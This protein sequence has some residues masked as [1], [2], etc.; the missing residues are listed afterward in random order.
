MLKNSLLAPAKL[1]AAALEKN[2]WEAA[3]KLR[4]NIDAAEYKHVVLGLFFLR[5][6]YVS[7][8]KLYDRITLGLPPYKG[9]NPEDPAPYQAE[10]IF[11]VPPKARWSVIQATSNH[12]RIGEVVEEAM[13]RIERDNPALDGVLSNKVYAR[14]NLDPATLGGL[15]NLVSDIAMGDAAARSTD[16]LGHVFEY[17]LGQFAKGE[18]KKG[19]QFYTPSTLVELLVEMLQ[20]F[21]GKIFD[22]CCGSG[23]MFVQSESFV[24]RHRRQSSDITVY[25]QESNQTTWRLAK[26]NL[27]IRG[28]DSSKVIWNSEGSFLRDAHRGLAADYILANPPFNDSDW[29][30]EQLRRD[31]RWVF[32]PPPPSN[33]NYAWLEHIISHLA[34]EGQAAIVLAKGA[35]TS[36]NYLEV[37]IR[38]RMVGAANLVDCV[39]SLP[40]KLFLN[41]QIPAAL[42]I[43]R[44]GRDQGRYRDRRN[45]ILFIDAV[46]LGLLVS[47]RSRVFERA[48][49]ERISGAYHDWR[50]PDGR[51]H[52]EIAF[53]RSV[54]VDMVRQLDFTLNPGLYVGFH[55]KFED[56]DFNSTLQGLKVELKEQLDEE[57]RLNVAILS[58]LDK[59]EF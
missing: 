58:S 27:A 43:L 5:H 36:R 4:K 1:S 57:A 19:G 9:V 48:D 55:D 33:A 15:I 8:Q 11:F 16:I 25:G 17:F 29:S 56:G 22:P 40:P 39:V 24:T 32:G 21:E 46:D 31:P 44:R 42:W 12:H 26:M 3:D 10:N 50:D 30:G 54:P 28:I 52:D 18:G 20:P 34:P 47:R 2:L 35:L 13:E 53:C 41:T 37:A 7:F 23:G 59:I 14:Q 6:I 38:R 51:Y 49:I 45:E